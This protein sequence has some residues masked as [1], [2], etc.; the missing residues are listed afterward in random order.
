MEQEKQDFKRKKKAKAKK[1]AINT[2]YPTKDLK[3]EPPSGTFK[4]LGKG[5]DQEKNLKAPGDD[6]TVFSAFSQ[7]ELGEGYGEN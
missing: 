7:M 5:K 2:K 3:I 4:D 1:K 6:G